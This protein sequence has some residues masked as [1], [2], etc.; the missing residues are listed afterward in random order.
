[1]YQSSFSFS[2]TVV[3]ILNCK[4]VAAI[5]ILLLPGILVYSRRL[6]TCEGTWEIA[7]CV[8]AFY[9]GL[10]LALLHGPLPILLRSWMPVV[11]QTRDVANSPFHSPFGDRVMLTT[12]TTIVK[13]TM[14]KGYI[15]KGLRLCPDAIG[16]SLDLYIRSE[17][18]LQHKR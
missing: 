8:L 4:T 14:L 16:S 13:I 15:L 11:S 2:A 12:T 3:R 18:R 7:L 5:L 10:T 1:M 17:G 9:P 6:A